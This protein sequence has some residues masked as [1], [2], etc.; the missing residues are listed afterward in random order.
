MIKEPRP[1]QPG[2]Y[3]K[4]HNG[5]GVKYEVAVCIETGWIVWF[6]GPFKSGKNDLLVA[7]EGVDLILDHGERYIADKAYLSQCSV[8][9]YDALN[10]ADRHYMRVVRGHTR[11]ST[12]YSRCLLCLAIDS[13]EILT[14]MDSMLIPLPISYR[15]GSCLSV[16]SPLPLT[17]RSQTPLP[18]RLVNRDMAP[19]GKQSGFDTCRLP[20]FSLGRSAVN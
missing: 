15:L 19:C 2:F 18:L 6:Y 11:R 5:P 20:L 4:K 12:G 14:S 9:P 13:D 3:C 7:R 17:F 8:I 10:D 16:F 1:F